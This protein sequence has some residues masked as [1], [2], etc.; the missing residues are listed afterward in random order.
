V[1]HRDTYERLPA[2]AEFITRNLLFV[3]HVALMGLEPT[4]F[5]KTN[6][7]ALWVDPSTMRPSSSEQCAHWHERGFLSQIYNHQLC[8]LPPELHQ[9]ARK[10]ISGLEEQHVFLRVRLMQSQGPVRRLFRFVVPET[11]RGIAPF[12]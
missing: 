1:I 9:F 11:K 2:F 12:V 8:V 3:D 5:A 7:E 4:G 10:S 6:L